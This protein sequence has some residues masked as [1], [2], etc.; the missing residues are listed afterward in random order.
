[1]PAAEYLGIYRDWVFE[2]GLTPNRVDA[3]SHLGVARDL[4]AAVKLHSPGR[5]LSE[6]LVFP[7]LSKFSI[8]NNDLDIDVIVENEEA[9]PRYSGLTLTGVTVA[10]SP[11][12]LKNLLKAVGLRPINNVVDITNY[13]LMELGQP[14]HAFDA[15]KIKGGKVVVRTLA[16]GSRF[17]TLDGVERNLS[18]NDLMIC[19]A[20][21]GMCIAGVFGGQDSG[22]TE[23]TTSL[24]L[25]SACFNPVYVRKTSKLHGLKTDAS[26]R[27]ERGS[28]PEMTLLAL[29]RAAVMICEI[30]G[31]KVSSD[32]K[33]IYPRPVEKKQV[34]VR[35]HKV[36]RLIGKQIPKEIVSQIISDLG[37]EIRSSDDEGLHI[38]VPAFKVDV[39]READ[40]IEEILR[41]YGYNQV[42]VSKEISFSMVSSP[43]PDRMRLRNVIA[44]HLVGMGFS[45]F[46][47]NSLTRSD[48]ASLLK[49]I[50]AENWVKILNPL[51]K[52][53][54]VLRAS[55]VFGALETLVWNYNRK[56]TDLKLF[57]YGSIYKNTG[58]Q[59][60]TDALKKYYEEEQLSLLISG[61]VSPANWHS[62]EVHADFYYLKASVHQ[63]LKRFGLNSGDFRA[64]PLNGS[65][66]YQYGLTYYDQQDEAVV[67]FGEIATGILKHFDIRVP[68][69]Y[70]AFHWEKLIRAHLGQRTR[71]AELPR[72]PEVRRDLALLLD[73]S[74]QY[75]R[76]EELAWKRGTRLLKKLD[77]FDV[78]EGEGIGEGKK[79][80]AVS[81]ILQDMEKTLTDEDI[82]KVMNSLIKAFNEEL[83]AVLR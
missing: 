55:L 72:F 33:D 7:D 61:R 79:S 4:V 9:C 59:D 16:P 34:H 62:A 26:F 12:W 18:G 23:S 36:N 43:M 6:E 64:E 19:N 37:M 65:D 48:Y 58:A 75:S 10:E 60:P 78:Y 27:F 57:E 8:D 76:I 29:K 45:E 49:E 35:Y 51:S 66:I 42:E 15:D 22:V 39:S 17:V 83:G 21:D 20:E 11:D 32:I 24:F 53:L 2:I 3:A 54:E 74:V 68:V 38:A 71:Y 52:D 44:D 63:V 50:Q 28:D 80:Y 67:D 30:A 31:G 13:V 70:A 81:F 77:L 73:K 46:M 14:L 1:M 41:I 56:Y 69:Y 40:V 25:E 5:L 47:C 82:D